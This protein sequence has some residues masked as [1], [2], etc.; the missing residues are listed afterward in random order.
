MVVLVGVITVASNIFLRSMRG[1]FGGKRGRGSGNS[2]LVI[3]ILALVGAI[4]APLAAMMI[5]L[6]VSRRREFLADSSGALLTRYPE[7]LANALVKISQYPVGLRRASNQT[8]H[9]WID[10]PIKGEAK[11]NWFHKLFMTH[12][13]VEDRIKALLGKVE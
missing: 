10:D 7:G 5:Q 6:A 8:A 1:G 12:P 9:L 2:G 3:L 11:T 4:L 13:S